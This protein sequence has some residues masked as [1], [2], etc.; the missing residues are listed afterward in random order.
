MPGLWDQALSH[1]RKWMDGDRPE[2][3]IGLA[4]GGGFARG[5]THLGVLRVFEK[6]HIPVKYLSGVSAGSIV[7]SAYASGTPLAEIERIARKMRFKDVAG[8][9]INRL[10][11]AQ[12]ERMTPFL[13]RLLKVYNFE[14]MPIPLAIVASDLLSGESAVFRDKGDALLPIRASC[15]YPGMFPPIRHEGRLLVDGMVTMD[16]PAPPLRTMGATHVIA[17]SLPSP[18]EAFDPQNMLSVISRSFQV[19]T[20]RTESQW[21]R[22]AD[23][24]LSPDVRK[25]GWDGF[26]NAD[27]LIEAGEVAAREALPAIQHWFADA[28]AK[29]ENIVPP[30]PPHIRLRLDD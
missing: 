10:G 26:E 23:L 25:I 9:T 27:Q 28:A 2:P 30:P 22:S 20:Q 1:A 12:S 16:V 7:A 14:E 6:H 11:L 21:R 17:I 18:A 4:L 8:W 15:A 13:K 3:R 5:I 19:L 29:A 24:V